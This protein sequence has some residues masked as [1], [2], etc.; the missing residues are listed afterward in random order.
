MDLTEV[1]RCLAEA[2]A[3]QLRPELCRGRYMLVAYGEESSIE[4][5][6]DDV[7]EE[8][9]GTGGVLEE[10]ASVYGALDLLASYLADMH[11]G[12]PSELTEDCRAE[13][14]GEREYEQWLHEDY[15]RHIPQLH[16]IRSPDRRLLA[17]FLMSY[18]SGA[19]DIETSDHWRNPYLGQT[20][21]LF[22]GARFVFLTSA[23]PPHQEEAFAILECQ[24][25]GALTDSERALMQAC[26]NGDPAAV[27]TALS[28]GARVDALDE[29]GMSPLHMAVAHRQPAVVEALLAAGADPRLQSE[30]GNA[31]HFAALDR[32]RRVGPSADRI[33]DDQ[34]WRMVR[35]L[36]DAGAEVNAANLTGATVLDLAIATVPYPE[37][38]I[39]YL[40]AHGARSSR[41]KGESLH[42]LL[43]SLPS[44]DSRSLRIRVNEVRHLLETGAD[45]NQPSALR[46]L[47]DSKGYDEHNVPGE[48]L[49][50]LADILLRHGARDNSSGAEPSALDW[51]ERWLESGDRNYQLVV[52]R[53]RTTSS[54]TPG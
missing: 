16:S 48:I 23:A 11:N 8:R 46:A 49:L 9:D 22:T 39:Q 40:V 24:P 4:E 17:Y 13:G 31:P 6:V 36:V 32:R 52:D 12:D 33:D 41:L 28:A 42:D 25:T 29:R 21:T 51:A 14:V 2:D 19:M 7:D 54:S 45:P 53:L 5:D 43:A 38:A 1:L 10:A 30:F 3:D 35:V 47:F 18:I 50:D 37:E 27:A 15:W 20:P 34:H 44:Q 26:R